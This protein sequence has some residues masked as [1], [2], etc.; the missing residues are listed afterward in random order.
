M[1]FFKSVFADDVES[2]PTDQPT[3]PNPNPESTAAWSFGG[4]MR[5]IAVKSESVIESYRKD[6]EELGS[7]LKKETEIIR[8]VASRAVNDSLEIGATVAQEKLESVGQAID[9]I[10]SSV[11]KS[12]AQIISNGKDT[13]LSLSDDDNS[14][15]ENPDTN[16]LNI[17]NSNINEKRYSRFEMQI[18]ALQSDRSTYCQEP[19]DLNDFEN[20]KSG[21]NLEDRKGEIESLFDQNPVIEDIFMDVASD[22]LESRRYWTNYF[23]KVS[24]LQKAEE[25]RVK[26]VKRAISGEEEEDLSWDIDEDDEEESGNVEEEKKKNLTEDGEKCL[27]NEEEK[28]GSSKDSDVSVVSSHVSMPE[29]EG[30]DEIEEIPSSDENK[31]EHVG[32]ANKVDLHK[33]LSVTE[34][35]EDLSWDIEDDEDDQPVKA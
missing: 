30:W 25:A 15:S 3:D 20:W 17:S 8:S 29:E 31:G 2:E 34:E 14:D 23:Y 19:E 12:T 11:W 24:K 10:G 35:D 6:L 5:T 32:N 33:R 9:D 13:F 1:D 18:R 7:G 26:L 28:A 21:F 22:E 27:K 4:I 16:R